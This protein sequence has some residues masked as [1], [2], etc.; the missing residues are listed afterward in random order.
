MLKFLK[1]EAQRFMK[2]MR[3]ERGFLQMLLPLAASAAGGYLANKSNSGSQVTDKKDSSSTT[4]RSVTPGEQAI[5]AL[6]QRLATQGA[7]PYTGQRVAGLTGNERAGL[8]GGRGIFDAAIPGMTRALSG[9]FPEEYF[10][11]AVA[12]PTRRQFNERVAPVM[13]E[14]AALTGNRFADRTAIEM[15]Q[16]RGDVESSILQQRGQWGQEAMY[17]PAKYGANVANALN[18]FQGLFANERLVEQ[19]VLDKQ[20]EEFLR[21]NP[22]SGGLVQM[23]L[24]YKPAATS[25]TTTGSSSRYNPTDTPENAWMSGIGRALTNYAAQS[26]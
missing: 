24:G 26:F 18:S 22:Y 14:N 20:Y 13:R 21:T 15:G 8:A 3:D 6:I 4:T 5:D 7:D 9:E 1:T 2:Y 19:D 10:N 12:D 25:S 11:Q 16:A 23:L 17:A